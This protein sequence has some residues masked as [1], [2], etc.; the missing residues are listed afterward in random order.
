[1]DVELR[2]DI[3]LMPSIDLGDDA[4]GVGGPDEG[5]GPL[6]VPGKI[7]VDG[8]L[9]LGR[10]SAV[11]RMIFARHVAERA[12]VVRDEQLSGADLPH[13]PFGYAIEPD[14]PPIE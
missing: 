12:H 5:R 3:R 8:D 9:D 11:A 2:P 14:H 4:V 13:L 7:A 1:M 6:I 10:A